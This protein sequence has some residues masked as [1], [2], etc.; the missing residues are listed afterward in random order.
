[1]ATRRMPT[2]P[3]EILR[4]EFLRPL[5]LTQRKTARAITLM[6]LAASWVAS[7]RQKTV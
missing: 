6:A 5:H 7:W 3:G 2:T 1:M 4:E